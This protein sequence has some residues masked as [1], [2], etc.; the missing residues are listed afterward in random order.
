MRIFCDEEW[1][2]VSI[3]IPVYNSEK[4]LARC[5]N[6]ICN[7]YYSNLEIILIDDGS[8]DKSFSICNEFAARDKRIRVIH[9]ENGGVSSARNIGLNIAQG[10]YITFVDSDDWVSLDML[11]KLL[12]QM[13]QV[14]MVVGGY[15]AV[16]K[17]GNLEQGFTDEELVFPKQVCEKFDTL[18]VSNFFNA[19]F[20]KIY[21]SSILGTQRFDI[22]VALGEDFLFNLEYLSKCQKIRTVSNVGY[23]YNCMNECA[24]TKKLRDNDIEQVIFLYKKGKEFLQKYR[25]NVSESMELKKRLCLNGVN[26]IQMIAYSDRDQDEKKTLAK[27]LLLNNEFINTCKEDYELPIKYDIPRKL[28]LHNN[29][30]CLQFFFLIKKSLSSIKGD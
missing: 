27:K 17:T 19:P 16:N 15:T 5:I 30:K 29:W 4:Y 20:A 2:M 18:Y 14:D 24:A 26:L 10:E 21:K 8:R 25:P 22:N 6:S 1:V 7:Q 3:I 12:L 9:K 11:E 13:E 23:F 28:C